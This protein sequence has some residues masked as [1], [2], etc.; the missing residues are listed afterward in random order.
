[1]ITNLLPIPF[2]RTCPVWTTLSNHHSAD[3]DNNHNNNNTKR[4]TWTIW[5]LNKTTPSIDVDT[6]I[7]YRPQSGDRSPF[8]RARLDLCGT[9]CHRPN[10]T[11]ALTLEATP[12][13]LTVDQLG[14][15]SR[16]PEP[17]TGNDDTR[18]TGPPSGRKRAPSGSGFHCDRESYSMVSKRRLCGKFGQLAPLPGSLSLL[19]LR[20]KSCL[21]S[22]H[23]FL[24]AFKSIQECRLKYDSLT[25]TCPLSM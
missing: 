17:T 8:L 22:D 9:K 21:V 25:L 7:A 20:Q 14:R 23:H 24:L 15:P 10:I 16:S 11:V 6:Q 5:A 2:T 13:P 1:M 3:N 12:S 19:T 18:A 4:T